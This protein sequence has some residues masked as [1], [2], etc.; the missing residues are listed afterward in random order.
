MTYT[1]VKLGGSVCAGP[2]SAPK[3]ARIVA[4][5]RGPVV[6]V[7]SALKGVTDRIYS[8]LDAG[9]DHEAFA[10]ELE[11]Q[12][13]DFARAFGPSSARLG[14]IEN[15]LAALRRGFIRCSRGAEPDR[16]ERLAS[17]G[18]RFSALAFCAALEPYGDPGRPP[19]AWPEDLALSARFRYG[20]APH[21]DFPAAG[22]AECPDPHASWP[23]L[24]RALV[25]HRRLSVPGFYGLAEGG[26]VALYG[27]GGSDYSAV[28]LASAGAARSCD[29]YKD[30]SGLRSA[31]PSLVGD[32]RLVSRL[33]YGE[34]ADLAQGGAKVLHPRCASLAA[35]HGVPLRILSAADGS[36]SVVCAR[37]GTAR[38]SR[39]VGIALHSARAAAA[40]AARADAG[41]ESL[42]SLSIVGEG[43]ASASSWAVKTI[44][45][46]EGLGIPARSLHFDPS[47]RKLALTVPQ[48]R[49][50][51]ALRGLHAAFFGAGRNA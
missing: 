16:N 5:Y 12:A 1:V 35:E 45:T 31:D 43:G 48:A 30:A 47:G 27:R 15:G 19:V 26:R 9:G 11:R 20:A 34:A 36:A 4:G 14:A 32:T 42:D 17:Y 49:G 39:P 18:E 50:L 2:E 44:K 38:R 25:E 10:R 22:E 51:E 6:F 28:A 46:L 21:G 29:L 33:S 8:F 41:T 7:L 24:R 3:L 40:G 13:L 37:V 23:A